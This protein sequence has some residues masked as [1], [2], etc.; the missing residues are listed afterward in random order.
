MSSD[1]VKN[2]DMVRNGKKCLLFFYTILRYVI[3]LFFDELMK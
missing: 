3:Q 1:E 2:M